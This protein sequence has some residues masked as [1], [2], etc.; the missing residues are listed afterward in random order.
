[1]MKSGRENVK[2]FSAMVYSSNVRQWEAAGVAQLN[3]LEAEREDRRTKE[4]WEGRWKER[5]W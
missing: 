5:Y 2:M 4:G 1:M 3:C